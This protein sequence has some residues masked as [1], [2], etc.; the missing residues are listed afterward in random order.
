MISTW[1]T[2]MRSRRWTGSTSTPSRS[3][4]SCRNWTKLNLSRIL[5]WFRTFV[6]QNCFIIKYFKCSHQ[7]L[8]RFWSSRCPSKRERPRGGSKF[9]EELAASVWWS[10]DVTALMIGVVCKEQIIFCLFYYEL[11]NWLGILFKFQKLKIAI[12]QQ[13]YVV[14][15]F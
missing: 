7:S 15:R 13:P 11:N 6:L 1:A 8:N 12:S 10:F 9:V 5:S 3:R 14:R 4:W 2:S